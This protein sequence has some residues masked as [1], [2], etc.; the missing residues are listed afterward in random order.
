MHIS[1]WSSYYMDLSPEDA[2]SELEKNGYQYAELSDEH[3]AVLL[4][5]GDPKTVGAAF[6][7][8]ADAHNV[9]FLQ[10]H[11]FLTVRLCDEKEPA[12]PILQKW[13]DLFCAIGIK[14]AVLHCD[15]MKDDPFLTLDE[16]RAKNKAAL[17]QLT[18]YLAG[19]DLVICL[20]NLG[21]PHESVESLLWYIHEI[22]DTHLGICLDTGH[23]NAFGNKKQ[24]PFIRKAGKHL[25]ALHIAD[26]EGQTDQHMMPYGKG[27]VDIEAVVRTL[28]EIGYDG[29]FNFEIPGERTCP[30]AVRGYKL[31]YLKKVCEYLMAL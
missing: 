21:Q 3:A 8:F 13:L 29:L 5:R 2:V 26:N 20:E 10:G 16:I 27:N 6:K 4:E 23:L 30:L 14:N 24:I 28:K 31:Q 9:H 11:L 1:M 22:G 12:V 19:K 25:K 7:A 18:D 15:A 17:V